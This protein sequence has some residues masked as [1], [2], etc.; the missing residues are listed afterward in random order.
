MSPV[1]QLPIKV[2]KIQFGSKNTVTTSYSTEHI[3]RYDKLELD[4]C[5]KS[6]CLT[7]TLWSFYFQKSLLI[8]AC[9]C[10]AIYRTDS[11]H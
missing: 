7:T 11:I 8:Q 1:V 9:R 2:E 5:D 4:I 3:P 10:V 6:R